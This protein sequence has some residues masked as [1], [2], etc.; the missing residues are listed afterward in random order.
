MV[1]TS[2]TS[3]QQLGLRAGVIRLADDDGDDSDKTAGTQ[4]DDHDALG[5]ADNDF[6]TSDSLEEDRAAA[7]PLAILHAFHQNTHLLS[8]SLRERI[9]LQ[10][11]TL[12]VSSVSA[13]AI[14]SPSPVRL[15]PADLLSV[16]L[17]LSACDVAVARRLVSGP[18]EVV[19]VDVPGR[20]WLGAALGFFGIGA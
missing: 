19:T 18:R 15:G 10:R 16:G 20:G 8:Q 6:R 3:R 5:R 14:G 9:R 1:A 7:L 12:P 11:D 17:S 2:G 4:A 13:T